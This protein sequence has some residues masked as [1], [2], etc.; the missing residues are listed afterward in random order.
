MMLLLAFILLLCSTKLLILKSFL[1]HSLF[2]QRVRYKNRRKHHFPTGRK[3]SKSFVPADDECQGVN[4]SI[5]CKPN[6]II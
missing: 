6:R 1:L 3:E 2:N 5:S 4:D